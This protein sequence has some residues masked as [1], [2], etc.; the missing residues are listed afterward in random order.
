MIAAV[1]VKACITVPN[2]RFSAAVLEQMMG[3]QDA[4]QDA[5]SVLIFSGGYTREDAGAISEAG[6]YWQVADSLD[7]FGHTSVKGR[8][9]LEVS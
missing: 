5:R 4:A 8:A 6:S 3:L 2:F 7:W 9:L 1:H